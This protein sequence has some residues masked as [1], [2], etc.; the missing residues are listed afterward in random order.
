MAGSCRLV[1]FWTRIIGLLAVILAFA[2]LQGCS[3]IKLAYNNSPELGY[4]WIDG[5]ADLDD[6]Q[7]LRVRE[8]LAKLQQW[9]RSTEML[10]IAELLQRTRRLATADTTPEQ[11][12]ALFADA[13]KRIDAVVARAEPATVEVAMGLRSEQLGHI[14]A[15]FAKGNAEWQD[16]WIAGGPT[17][18]QARRLK[19]SVERSEQFYGT[20]E[21]RQLAVLRASIQ[22]SAFDPQLSY[23]ERLRRQRDMLQA[24]RQFT[25]APG[26]PRPAVAEATA[27][28][29]A[30]LDRSVNS[31]NPAY[32]AYAERAISDSCRTFA[33]LHNSTTPEQRERA[34]RRLAAYERDARELALNP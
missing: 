31:P 7:S 8:E 26:A 5:Y 29:R 24:L 32:R 10:K 9:H 22:Q 6:V 25:A 27:T 23:A 19:S 15:K 20:L 33:Q 30:V 2:L 34:A 4:W 11:V 1:A 18:R 17:E 3:A 13:R 16:E 28:L 12:C 14:E 21:E